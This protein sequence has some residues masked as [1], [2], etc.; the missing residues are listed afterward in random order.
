MF[1]AKRS[2]TGT[3]LLLPGQAHHHKPLFED[4]NEE[5]RANLIKCVTAK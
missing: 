4:L 1:R 2:W 3:F 5:L